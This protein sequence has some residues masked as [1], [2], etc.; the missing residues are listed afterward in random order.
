MYRFD[1]FNVLKLGEQKLLEGVSMSIVTASPATA[2]LE[3]SFSTLD[4][5][6]G[7]L[8]AQLGNK[9]AGKLAFFF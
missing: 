5:T 4:L 3:R 6:Y 7:K 2:S 8:R 9:K 1:G